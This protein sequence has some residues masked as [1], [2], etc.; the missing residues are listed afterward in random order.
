[1][2]DQQTRNVHACALEFRPD[3]LGVPVV[4]NWPTA[5]DPRSRQH[6][7]YRRSCGRNAVSGDG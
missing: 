4:R 5:A 7:S 1:M 6:G 3:H 2:I